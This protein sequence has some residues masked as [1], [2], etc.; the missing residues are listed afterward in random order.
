[1][2]TAAD[3]TTP[4]DPHL[5]L[6]RPV[7]AQTPGG[8]EECLI[9]GSTWVHLRLC[10]TCGNVGCCDSSPH[11]HARV[12]ALAAGHPIVQSYEPDEDW[13]WCYVDEA[14]V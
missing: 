6:V 10:L 14:F 4:R 13:R 11:Q 8:C 7:S 1:M 2:P 12:H 3:M 9:L 5:S